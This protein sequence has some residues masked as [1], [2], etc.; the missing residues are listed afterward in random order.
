[1]NADDA[2]REREGMFEEIVENFYGFV[3]VTDGS[4]KALYVNN[5]VL[6]KYSLTREEILNCTSYDMINLGILRQSAVVDTLNTGKAA[7]RYIENE[8][9]IPVI[10]IAKPLF[11][12][13]GNIRRIIAFSQDETI[14]LDMVSQI[15]D[16]RR[17]AHNMQDMP[18]GGEARDPIVAESQVMKELLKFLKTVAA[19]DSTIALYGESGTGKEVLAKYIHSSS[20]RRKNIFFP[21]N[22]AAIPSELMEAELFGYEKGSF[23]GANKE[24]KAGLFEMVNGGTLFLDEIGDLS[25]AFQAKLLRVI[26]NAE[27]RRIGGDKLIKTNVR[28]ITATNRNLKAMVEEGSFRADLYY[29]LHT[30][31]VIVPPLRERKEDILALAEMFLDVYNRKYG[32]N[33]IFARSTLAE[34]AAYNW[35][36]NVRELRNAV[37][38]MAIASQPDM[39]IS[40]HAS[41]S[42][43]AYDPIDFTTALNAQPEQGLSESLKQMTKEFERMLISNM[44]QKCDVNVAECA[45]RLNLHRSALYRKLSEHGIKLPKDA[46]QKNKPES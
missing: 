43:F 10:S 12:E 33:K 40:W 9:D 31:P 30:I 7:I 22:C 18:A 24:G 16:E 13:Q 19:F 15:F 37:E 20:K 25:L 42:P 3:L 26:D 44:L 2:S 28:L 8:T 29:R 46:K 45:K 41:R 5:N 32:F 27:V 6:K 21:F 35:P 11:D 36:G 14:P 17:L 39:P 34:L 1:M 38:Q 23:T 4:G